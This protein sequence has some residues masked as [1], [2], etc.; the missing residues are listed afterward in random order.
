MEFACGGL[1]PALEE[2]EQFLP[3]FGA[4]HGKR[5]SVLFAVHGRFPLSA[6]GL[7]PRYVRNSIDFFI[8][9]VQIAAAYGKIRFSWEGEKKQLVL[10]H[11]S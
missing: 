9:C 3:G 7:L 6:C 4:A 5:L 11:C 2:V 1:H 8:S 10:L